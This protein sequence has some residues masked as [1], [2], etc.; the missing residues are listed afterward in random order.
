MVL[1]TSKIYWWHTGRAQ[2]PS[3]AGRSVIKMQTNMLFHPQRRFWSLHG[4]RDQRWAVVPLQRPDGARGGGGGGGGLQALHPVLHP[5]RAGAA[6][7]ARA[8]HVTQHALTHH[9]S[10]GRVCYYTLPRLYCPTTYVWQCWFKR[11]C[12]LLAR[13]GGAEWNNSKSITN[14]IGTLNFLHQNKRCITRT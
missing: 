13:L 7:A 4:V 1:K 9:A 12:K 10:N 5:P 2:H 11:I 14:D 6:A 3:Q 8:R